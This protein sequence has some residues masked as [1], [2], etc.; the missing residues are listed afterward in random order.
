MEAEETEQEAVEIRSCGAE[1]KPDIAIKCF[2]FG[3]DGSYIHF[4]A[5]VGAEVAPVSP[6]S[7]KPGSPNHQEGE[8]T[9]NAKGIPR[10]RGAGGQL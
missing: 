2:A 8:E 4:P 1:I 6:G 3:E 5:T 10:N 9:A 7:I